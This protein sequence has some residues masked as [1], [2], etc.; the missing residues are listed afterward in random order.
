M[1]NPNRTRALLLTAD[2]SL[3]G[4]FSEIYRELNIHTESVK[5]FREAADRLNRG[6]YE[7]VVLDADTVTSAMLELSEL[8]DSFSNRSAVRFVVATKAKDN[9]QALER[10]AHFLFHRP[11]RDA[12]IRSTLHSA[13][14]LMVSESRRYFRSNAQLPVTIRSPQG[15]LQCSTLN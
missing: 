3:D 2:S 12:E 1:L 8:R 14:D 13:Y 11:V 9:E 4:S 6:K 5:D 15:M 7:A 10:G